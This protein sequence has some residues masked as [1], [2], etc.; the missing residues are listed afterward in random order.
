MDGGLKGKGGK[1]NTYEIP[2]DV[3]DEF[4]AFEEYRCS[5]EEDG[6]GVVWYRG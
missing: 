1:A 3:G 6:R 2:V 4:F 5:L